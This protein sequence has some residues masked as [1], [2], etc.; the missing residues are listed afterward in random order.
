VG[1]GPAGLQAAATAAGRGHHVTVLERDDRPGGDVRRAASVPNRAEFGDLIRNQLAACRAVGVD[2]RTGV[3]A[4]VAAVM[5]LDPD[6]VVVAT[7]SEPVTPP[8][9]PVGAADGPRFTDLRAVL[10]GAVTPTGAVLV[11][12]ELGFH[13]STSVAELLADRGCTVEIATPGMV[14]GQDLGITLDLEQ[15][16]IRSAAKH[17]VQSTDLVAMGVN[18]GVVQLLHH[19]TGVTEPRRVDWVVLAVPGAAADALYRALRR[20]V[21]T[22]AVHRVGDCVAPRRAHAAVIEGDAVGASL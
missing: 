5:A 1:A 13:P 12:D 21:P 6:V 18:A 16:N 8:W 17:I 7:G 2:L 11:I 4:D 20:E 10:D 15:W 19:P 14:V 22:L 9:V 3:D